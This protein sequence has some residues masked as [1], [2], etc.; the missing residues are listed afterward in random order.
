MIP[1]I[2]Y[3]SLLA[4]RCFALSVEATIESFTACEE[5]ITKVEIMATEL[6]SREI[7]PADLFIYQRE[8][9]WEVDAAKADSEPKFVTSAE[10]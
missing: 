5:N 1:T 7:L 6:M 4:G 10:R 2:V 3:C 9:V 8:C